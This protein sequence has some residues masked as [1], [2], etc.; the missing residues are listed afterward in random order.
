MWMNFGRSISYKLT[1]GSFF[2]NL[3]Y[4][5]VRWG[6]ESISVNQALG[7]QFVCKP[8]LYVSIFT[9]D[10]NFVGYS[11][12]YFTKETVIGS[13]KTWSVLQK[14][15]VEDTLT[16]PFCKQP[17][18]ITST[19]S[20]IMYYDIN[21]FCILGCTVPV[22]WCTKA[23]FI[24]CWNNLKYKLSVTGQHEDIILDNVL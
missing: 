12:S 2:L 13:L 20:L 17:N 1:S 19:T 18:H 6:L 7:V 21:M 15:Q 16:T 22:L 3:S 24:C 5:N 9:L 10:N 23:P 14:W 8:S 4:E 11:C